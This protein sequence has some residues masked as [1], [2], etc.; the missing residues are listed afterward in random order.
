MG[1]QIPQLSI[2]NELTDNDFWRIFAGVGSDSLHAD[3]PDRLIPASFQPAFARYS[4]V[5]LERN[6]NRKTAA[7]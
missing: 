6:E 5:N 1:A 3:E 2:C 7:H 4:H